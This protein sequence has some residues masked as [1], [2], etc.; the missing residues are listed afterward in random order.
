MA[1]TNVEA[2]R[3]LIGLTERSPFY[4]L[5]SDEEIGWFL[6][7]SDDNIINASIAA[8]FAACNFLSQVNTKEKFGDIEAWNEV[9]REYKKSFALWAEDQKDT[10]PLPNGVMP[11][12]AGVSVEDLQASMNNPDNPRRLNWLYLNAIEVPWCVTPEYAL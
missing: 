1:L 4:G 5:I 9:A 7:Q 3:L 6:E 2:V 10:N 12:A 8:G 11:W